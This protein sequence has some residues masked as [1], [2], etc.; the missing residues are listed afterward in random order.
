M[1]VNDLDRQTLQKAQE[2]DA[3]RLVRRE[4]LGDFNFAPVEDQT[5]VAIVALREVRID[6]L[7]SLPDAYSRIVIDKATEFESLFQEIL[8]FDVSK[9]G[10]IQDE[11]QRLIYSMDI[12][13]R[14]VIEALRPV[15][16]YLEYDRKKRGEQSEDEALQFQA[17][18]KWEQMTDKAQNEH[19]K[20][21]D[22][23]QQKNLE[24]EK[25]LSSA[26]TMLEDAQ[27]RVDEA[28][29]FILEKAA[30]HQA[31]YFAEESDNHGRRAKRWLRATI[32]VAAIAVV[33]LGFAPFLTQLVPSLDTGKTYDAIQLALS[34]TLLLGVTTY[35]LFLCARNFLSHEHNA[36]VN[37]HRQNALLT[38]KS[39]AN[40]TSPERRDVILE[41]AASC[42]FSPQETGYTRSSAQTN[43]TSVSEIIPKFMQSSQ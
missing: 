30:E 38:Y 40:A 42:I 28:N 26:T 2:L 19:L 15:T 5:A 29:K 4:T 1:T 17:R 41:H 21:I 3:S 20:I 39:I 33:F 18:T 9:P 7:D 32:V 25:R 14:S 11:R 23:A 6:K 43:I 35:I 37:K 16:A 36:I 27:R 12:T 13:I 31:A 10:P 34:K 22:S 8:N 24:I